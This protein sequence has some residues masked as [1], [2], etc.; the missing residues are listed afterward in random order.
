M[1]ISKLILKD[2]LEKQ[3]TPASSSFSPE[4]IIE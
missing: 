2:P 3:V 1:D 4:G